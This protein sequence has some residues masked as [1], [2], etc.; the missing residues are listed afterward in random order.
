MLI[1]ILAPGPA[2]LSSPLPL[3]V[4]LAAVEHGA[5][6]PAQHSDNASSS[7]GG[8]AGPAPDALPASGGMQP[9]DAAMGLEL[10]GAALAAAAAASALQLHYPSWLVDGAAGVVYR[11]QLDL[12][13]VADCCQSDYPRL[14]AFL[15]RRRPA[16]APRRD[17]AGITLRVLRLIMQDEAPLGLLR[18]AF[19]VV[20]SFAGEGVPA[21][22]QQHSGVPGVG[23][24]Q[25]WKAAG[26]AH[27]ARPSP[28]H[29]PAATQQQHHQQHLQQQQPRPVVTPQARL[30]SV[31]AAW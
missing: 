22:Q 17:A 14:L 27:S 15:Q 8:E 6:Q 12:A 28:S 11:L 2:P 26:L 19:D 29:S 10:P 18:T 5:E 25:H 7:V 1:D 24:A 9:P 31:H 23:V 30:C 21:L 3:A 20:N 16:A 4:P 13:A